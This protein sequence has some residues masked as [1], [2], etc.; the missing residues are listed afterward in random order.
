MKISWLEAEKLC[1]GGIPIG[2]TDLQ[3][4]VDQG[5]RAILTLTDHPLNT[6]KELDDETITAFGITVLH[7]PVTDQKA[8]TQA[9][10]QA[11]HDFIKQMNEQK[12]PVF[13]HCHT[14]VGRT[15]TA[16]HAHYLLSGMT[17]TEAQARVKQTRPTSQ[18]IMLSD[19][20]KAFLE[21]FAAELGLYR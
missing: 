4:L 20:Q 9:Q 3:S 6:Q 2:K 12:L 10:A 14:G 21:H 11:I 17:F 19:V 13:I 1:A 15:R 18:Y 7:V 5:V 16:L 8:P